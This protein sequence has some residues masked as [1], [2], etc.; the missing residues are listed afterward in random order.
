MLCAALG[1]AVRYTASH[2]AGERKDTLGRKMKK[3]LRARVYH[4]IL[5][6]GMRGVDG[7]SMAG[8]TQ[9]SIEGVEQLDLYYSS[10]LPQFF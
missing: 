6:L 10:Y 3:D 7:M 8:L 2:L 9:V 4:K 5:T 1:I